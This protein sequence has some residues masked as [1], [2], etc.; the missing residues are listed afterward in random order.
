MALVRKLLLFSVQVLLLPVNLQY[1]EK[2]DQS[3][4]RN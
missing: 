4:L 2:S 3:D 1:Q